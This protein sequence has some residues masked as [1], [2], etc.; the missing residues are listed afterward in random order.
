MPKTAVPLEKQINHTLR[1]QDDMVETAMK[2]LTVEVQAGLEKITPVKTGWAASNWIASL[3]QPT[4]APIGSKK[5]V[6][7]NAGSISATKVAA[8]YRFPRFRQVHITNHVPYVQSLN[9]GSTPT[10]KAPKYF[11]QLAVRRA[12]NRVRRTLRKMKAKPQPN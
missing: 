7:K 9:D 1:V 3:E 6:S 8:K 5:A 10:A 4:T 11:V 2:G 12:V